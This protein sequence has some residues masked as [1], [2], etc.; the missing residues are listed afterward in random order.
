MHMAID[1]PSSENMSFT[2]DRLRAGA[3]NNVDI[4]LDVRVASFADFVNFAVFDTDIGL[5]DAPPVDD[6]RIGNHRIYRP[7][8]TGNGGLSMPSRIT[9]PPPNFTSSP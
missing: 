7:I 1:A 8:S 4:V 6:Q 2:G 9:F 5:D 3:N